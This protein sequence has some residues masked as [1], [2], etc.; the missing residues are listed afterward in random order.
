MLM[1]LLL[2]LV[3]FLGVKFQDNKKVTQMKSSNRDLTSTVQAEE[4]EE[5]N[6]V[7][8]GDSNTEISY[9]KNAPSKRWSYKIQEE[10]GVNVRNFGVG[11]RKTSDF[12]NS[13]KIDYPTQDWIGE[14]WKDEDADY[15]IISFGLNDISHYKPD[16]FEKY[17]REMLDIIEKETSGIPIL[18]TNVHVPYPDHYSWNR[19]ERIDLYDDVKREIAEELNIGLIDVNK[20]FKEEFEENDVW[21]TRI[22]TTEIWGD[23]EDKGKTIESGWFDDIH[24]NETGNDIVAEEVIKYF[25]ENNLNN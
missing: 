4:V 5:P 17:T 10:L 24:Y 1:S 21:D 11:G 6:V 22:R 20:R 19:N 14:D 8:I 18:M 7:L 3:I 13:G 2:I 23:Q 9:F 15:F 16:E 12:L 25:K